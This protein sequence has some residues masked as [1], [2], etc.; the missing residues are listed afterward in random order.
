MLFCPLVFNVFAIDYSESM[1]D[2]LYN[3]FKNVENDSTRIVFLVEL[4]YV[5]ERDSIECI[6]ENNTD[7][8]LLLANDIATDSSLLKLLALNIDKKGVLFRIDG[9]YVS[10]LKFHNRSRDIAVRIKDKNLSSIVANNIGV[11]YRRLDDYQS[12]LQNHLKALKMAEETQNAKSQA[13][14]INSIG[15]IH[16]MIGNYDEALESFKQS[17]IIEQKL[18]NLLGIAI[19]LNNIG[20][21]YAE[22]EDYV[23]AYEYFVLSLDVNKEINSQRGI[24]IC[25]SDIARVYEHQGDPQRALSFYLE[26]IKIS[27]LL[28]DKYSLAYSYIQ[29]G[30]LYNKMGKYDDAL[31]YLESGVELALSI[32]AK[33]FITDGYNALYTIYR[34][35]KKYKK[36]FEY[37]ELAHQYH[38]SI[39]NVNVRKDIARLQ[40][41]YESESKETQI[42]LLERNASISVLNEKRHDNIILLILSALIIAIGFVVFLSYY[43][44]SKNITNKLLLDRNKSMEKAKSELDSYSKQLLH[45]KQDAENNSKVKS[46]FL[47]NMSHEIRTP[48]NSVIGFADIMTRTMTDPNHISQLNL[49]KSSGRSL[50]TLLNDILDLSKIEAGKYTIDYEPIHPEYIFEDVIQIFSHPAIEKNIELVA[51][52]SFDMPSIISFSEL[53]LRQILFNIVGNAIKFTNNGSII[54]DAASIIDKDKNELELTIEITDTGIGISEEDIEGVFEPFYQSKTSSKENGTGLGLTITKRLVEMMGGRIMLTSNEGIGTKFTISLPHIKILNNDID[55]IANKKLKL[56]NNNLIKI[57]VLA[58]DNADSLIMKYIGDGFDKVIASNLEEAKITIESRNVVVICGYPSDRSR[59]AISVLSKSN[60]DGNLNFIVVSNDSNMSDITITDRINWIRKSNSESSIV[61][62]LN[63]VFGIIAL[64]EKSS[65]FFSE[66]INSTNLGVDFYKDID[67]IYI[68]EYRKAVKTK[69]SS[70]I[71]EFVVALQIF[72][73]KYNLKGIEQYCEELR[74]YVNSFEIDDLEKLLILFEENYKKAKDQ[75]L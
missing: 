19:N 5:F 56:E 66:L 48:L 20:N 14:A 43:L 28:T 73:K 34:K 21:V 3:E 4:A 49:I 67:S 37:L 38:D 23:K 70:I 65:L 53:R 47:A 26:A 30:S 63:K 64:E 61:R 35:E 55:D 75:Q 17:L 12:A 32:G 72:S 16:M 62:T 29:I 59:N 42:A 18:D 13:V 8:Y 41:K 45:A 27:K 46:E 54:V 22:K 6:S 24:A 69:M 51:N 33:A 40:I 44:Y 74:S 36:A 60:I 57:L 2:S 1:P 7:V 71:V 9:N 58:Y 25:Y 50:L 31:V 11:V 52:I 15:N 39:L 68:N 10:A